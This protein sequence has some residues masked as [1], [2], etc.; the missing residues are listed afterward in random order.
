M[1]T[2]TVSVAGIP[3][4]NVVQVAAGQFHGLAVVDDGGVLGWGWN[5]AGQASVPPSISNIVAVAAG[6]DFSLA[7]A[8]NGHVVAWGRDFVGEGNAPVVLS[9]AIAIT[10]GPSYGVSISENG[11]L[12]SISKLRQSL[13][14]AKSTKRTRALSGDGDHYIP[15]VE[16]ASWPSLGGALHS[17][18]NLMAAS[19][20]GAYSKPIALRRD[21]T[22]VQLAPEEYGG[23]MPAPAG[24]SN[25]VSVAMGWN[26]FLALKR[27]GTVFG[28]GF[29]SAGQATGSA[30]SH[31]GG[32][33]N[34]SSGLVTLTGQTLT[35]VAAIAACKD[36]SLALKRDG[37]LVGWGSN[38]SR[39]RDIPAGLSN[40]IAIA[41]SEFYCLAITTNAAVAEQFRK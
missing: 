30:T 25:V 6:N 12:L 38:E 14:D 13:E 29:N 21:G 9:N 11:Q 24:L 36:F 16:V 8:E 19:V 3:L 40:V 28:W 7:L 22:V 20:S 37:T 35:N 2:G 32:G 41:A 10:A 15:Q 31:T 17:N 33:A 34:K 26:H 27:D 5:H 18:S 1:W 39:G 23:G 4:S